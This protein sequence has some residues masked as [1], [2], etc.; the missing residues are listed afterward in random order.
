MKVVIFEYVSSGAYLS[1]LLYSD[2]IAE[3]DLMVNALGQG[4]VDA[5]CEVLLFRAP[6]W[7]PPQFEAK[8]IAL[9]EKDNWRAILADTLH[10]ADAYI[11][12][13]PESNALLESL[14]AIA[15]ATDCLLL[16][17]AAE[18]VHQTT[19]KYDTLKK[20]KA[21]GIPCVA[22]C[23]IDECVFPMPEDRVIKPNDSIACNHTYLIRAGDTPTAE[24]RRHAHICQ[25]YLSGTTASLSVIYSAHA[26]PCIL[27]V[28]RQG[29]TIDEHGS[30]EL[31][32]C[33]VNALAHLDLDFD[34]LAVALQRCFSGLIGYVGIDFIIDDNIPYVLEI[35]PRVTTS[36]AGLEKTIAMNPCAMLL[37]A[38]RGD[39]LHY[40]MRSE[41]TTH[42][43][44]FRGG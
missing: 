27:G 5:G 42:T 33:H 11:P 29:I 3:A 43:I 35:N 4:M 32:A 23:N 13:A 30:F 37:A 24:Q 8:I 28:N 44:D 2:L 34:G 17:S 41:F 15:T 12:V 22:C 6:Y 20:L 1:E 10:G 31:Q 38:V 18:T 21:H 36:F 19:D 40:P 9:T 25:P 7:P 26:K 39:P 14:C 16:N